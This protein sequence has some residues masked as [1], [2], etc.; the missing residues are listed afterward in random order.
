MYFQNSTLAIQYSNQNGGIENVHTMLRMIILKGTVYDKLTQWDIRKCV[1]H[2]NNAPR[3]ALHGSTPYLEACKIYDGETITAL[4]LRYVAP[5][6]VMLAPK[7][8][9]H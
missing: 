6:D 5:D 8:L 9:K 1:D 7:L 2:I 3:K 4:Q